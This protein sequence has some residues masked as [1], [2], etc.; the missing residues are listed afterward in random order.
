MDTE[1]EGVNSITPW[2]YWVIRNRNPNMLKYAT[3][4]AKCG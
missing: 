3:A 2:K 4:M 1:F